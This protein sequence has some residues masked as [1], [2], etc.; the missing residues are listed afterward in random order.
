MIQRALNVPVQSAFSQ[1]HPYSDTQVP[2]LKSH[3][4]SLNEKKYT[5]GIF[6]SGYKPAM[7]SH[8]K[9]WR[10][11]WN[12]WQTSERTHP[13]KI[14]LLDKFVK[15]FFPWWTDF[16][17][18]ISCYS[19]RSVCIHIYFFKWLVINHAQC[20]SVHLRNDNNNNKDWNLNI[21]RYKKK[22]SAHF[23]SCPDWGSKL[24]TM[25]KDWQNQLGHNTKWKPLL[26]KDSQGRSFGNMP[27]EGFK[28][29]WE[30]CRLKQVT[31]RL[32]ITFLRDNFEQGS[33][34]HLSEMF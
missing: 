30:Q 32:E 22:F 14:Q 5:P 15:Y 23:W 21:S 4:P 18:K 10:N 26:L 25:V 8:Q 34:L 27:P 24:S 2:K 29:K 28:I 31:R 7:L 1:P 19:G 16:L 17:R 11:N 13:L 33:N 12:R 9:Q 6:H 3:S 20:H